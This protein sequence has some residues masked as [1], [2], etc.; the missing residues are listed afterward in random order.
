MAEGSPTA[1]PV[2]V[3]ALGGL[4]EIGL[5]LIVIEHAGTAI[6]IDCGVMFPDRPA[7]G[8]GLFT[9]DLTW[10]GSSGLK[11]LGVILTHGHEDHI[12]ALPQLLQRFPMPVYGTPMTLS[13]ARRRLREFDLA[14]TADLRLFWPGDVIDLGPF[15]IE[16][17]RVTHSTPDS[18]ALA[19]DTPAG[20][21]VHSG[22]FKIDDAPVDG[23]RFDS[24]RFGR[25]GDE[26]VAL[27]LSDSTN[28]ERPGRCGSESSLTPVLREKARQCKGKF[29]VSAFSSHIHRIRQVVDVS[30]ETSRRV[31]PLGRRAIE[32]VRFGIEHGQLDYPP[33]TF[34]DTAEAEFLAPRNLTFFSGGSQAEPNSA[35]SRLAADVHPRIHIDAGDTVVLS[36]RAIPGNERPIN[37]L[38][39]ELFRRG[40]NVLH[41]AVAR[42]HVSGHAYRDE[43]A[44]LIRLVRP[45]AFVPIHG[46]YRHLVLHAAL[47]ADT[48]VAPAACF[49]LENGDSLLFD[50]NGARR[51][52]AVRAGR[53]ASDGDEFADPA[54]VD[55]RRALAHGGAVVAIVVVAAGSG[56]IV[57]GPEI[58]SRGITVGDGTSALMRQASADLSARLAQ[59]DSL[60][61]ASDSRL[62]GNIVRALREFFD[63]TIGRRPLVIAHV[64]EVE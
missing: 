15:R 24:E 14:G 39:N 62:R 21:I 31:V 34:I 36:S 37:Q 28:V 33:G 51:G 61:G 2:R 60:T 13:F 57:G 44:E 42:V 25:L 32:S 43:L 64:M 48:G 52:A 9:P 17:I 5:N 59:I 26:G 40:A 11:F 12:G 22:D 41:E 3:V 45:R 55:E 7:F 23:I 54:L 46:E 10:L 19:I 56:R 6:V 30:R 47:A 8:A 16:A 1:G 18:I 27:L 58:V 50:R 49:I 29:F 53:V 4:G 63:D 38:V 35:L 20:M